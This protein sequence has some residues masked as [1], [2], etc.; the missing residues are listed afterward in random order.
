MTASVHITSSD[1]LNLASAGVINLK[2]LTP[3]TP[4]NYVEPLLSS[5]LFSAGGLKMIK[6]LEQWDIIY[7][8]LDTASLTIAF[9]AAINTNYLVTAFQCSCGPD[10]YPEVTLTV[11]KPSSASMIKAYGSSIDITVVGGF[12]L[13]NVY[14]ATAAADFLS[15]QCSVSMQSLEGMDETSGDF[16]VDG[17]YRYGF[18]QECSAEAY[19]AITI[20][21]TAHASPNA[22]STPTESAEGFQIYSAAWWTYLDPGV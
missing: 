1:P 10:K 13:V 20:P 14:G 16:M 17:I 3:T 8:L 9:G 15:S 12:G 22:P 4:R 7:E 11:I 19:G 18:K 2:K 6:P 5:G 21:G